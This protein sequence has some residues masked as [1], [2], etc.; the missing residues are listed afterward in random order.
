MGKRRCMGEVLATAE[1]FLFTV[2]LVQQFEFR[3]PEGQRLDMD[4][5]SGIIG[6][7]KDFEAIVKP[8]F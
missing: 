2:G 8:R 4:P 7:P 6:Y 5:I 1:T 3:E